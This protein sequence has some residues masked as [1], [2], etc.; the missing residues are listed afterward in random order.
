MTNEVCCKIFGI[1][2]I[3]NLP[4]AVMDVLVGPKEK[5]NEI[6]GELLKAN[7]YDVSLDWFQ[8]IYEAELSEGKRKGQHFT[9]V[10]VYSLVSQLTGPNEGRI[11][12]PTAGT[13]GLIIGDWWEKCKTKLPWEA[14]PSKNYVVAWELS[15]R[16]IPLL[17][18]NLSIRG[19]MGEI[20]HGDVLEQN[21]FTK[22][23]LFNHNNDALGFSDVI[24]D[25]EQ[26]LK[27]VPI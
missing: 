8:P 1:R 12:E 16:A 3:M 14:F 2:D 21:V 11:H 22:Y 15:D 9:P 26:N 19:I 25:R 27:I 20:Y 5:R 23:I 24:E 17:L 18:L 4:M 7:N 6:F 13:G 10:E